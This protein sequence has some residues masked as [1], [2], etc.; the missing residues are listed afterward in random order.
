MRQDTAQERDRHRNIPVG[1][2]ELRLRPIDN[3]RQILAGRYKLRIKAHDCSTALIRGAVALPCV[4]NRVHIV[5]TGGTEQQIYG[6]TCDS[7]EKGCHQCD[8]PL[9]RQL[10]HFSGPPSR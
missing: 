3:D 9:E 10:L 2:T 4:R 7:N 6:N 8:T 1:R 5:H